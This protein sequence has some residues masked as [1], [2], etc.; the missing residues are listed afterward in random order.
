MN[1]FKNLLQDYFGFSQREINGFVILILLVLGFLAVSLFINNPGNYTQAQSNQDKALLQSLMDS[2]NLAEVKIKEF[3]KKKYA[4][5]TERI[6]PV[7]R[8]KPKSF[9]KKK[10]YAYERFPFD[11]NTATKQ[12]LM[13]LGLFEYMAERIINYRSKGGEFR[14]K[15][16]LNKIYKFPQKLYT[17]LAPF[18]QLPDSIPHTEKSIIAFQTTS[19]SI[20][21][22]N[23]SQKRKKRE[24]T[25]FDLNKAGIAELK[26]DQWHW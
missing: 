17:D 25:S 23:E 26:A 2:I 20:E 19:A 12:E 7:Y 16:D 1:F 24:I 13:R 3:K 21:K 22:R 5:K 4:S 15:S 10:E 18:I 9:N 8:N 11:P 6:P 14:V